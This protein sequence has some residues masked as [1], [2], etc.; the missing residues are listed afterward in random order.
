MQKMDK[1]NE[2]IC[3]GIALNG[4]MYCLSICMYMNN[5]ESTSLKCELYVQTNIN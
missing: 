2:Y 3:M 4:P 1:S 5:S